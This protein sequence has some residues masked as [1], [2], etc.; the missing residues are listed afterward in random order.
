MSR[1]LASNLERNAHL[2]KCPVRTSIRF[3]FNDIDL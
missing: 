3:L 2:A 1:N